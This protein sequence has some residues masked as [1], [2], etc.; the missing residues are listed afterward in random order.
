[1]NF[2][3]LKD[4]RVVVMG[5]GLYKQGSGGMAA[6]FFARRGA[7]VLV[8]DLR[9][10][11]ALAPALKRLKKFE[12][13]EYI[14]GKHRAR[15]FQ[16]ADL[17][18]Q[19]PSVPADSPYLKIAKKAGI[20]IVND[21]SI[22]LS[23]YSPKVFVG[24]TGTRGKSTTTALIFEMLK[25]KH[26]KII[27]AGNL[28]VSPLSFID[29]YHGEPIVAELSSWLLHH[30]FAVKKSPGVAVV[31]NI[32]NDHMDKYR[33][34]GGYI[35][36]KENIFRFQK[37][38][39]T[40]VLNWDNSTTRG[41][42]KKALGRVMRFSLK[43][44]WP[45]WVPLKQ[46]KLLGEHNLAN[47]LAAAGAGEAA[48]V[49]RR[50]IISV[51]KTFKGLP[52]RLELA[53]KA[54]GVRYYND[55]T[56]TTPE[57]TIAALAALAPLKCKMQKSKC[58]IIVLI[59]GG[60]DKKLNYQEL[61]QYI[62]RYCKAVVLLPGTATEKLKLEIGNWKLEIKE[63]VSMHEAIR[64]TKDIATKGDI[65]LLSPAA[66]SFGLF[67]NEFDRGAQFVREVKRLDS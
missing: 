31:T 65:I 35:A 17:V 46:V 57:A 2:D 61:A 34:R 41:M 51:L 10:A 39:D 6:Q 18:F 36:D 21:W 47:A 28:G 52:N 44:H 42:A 53:R 64:L 66:A 26:K 59:A 11:K 24:V 67:K 15:D 62:K 3:N 45:K 22:F 12:N 14:L 50:D 8:T 63:A 1:M 32:F 5:L 4:K 40:V 25:R 30:F 9:S 38:G 19:N 49:S 27:L 48:G 55:T 43:K 23:L 58:K 13:I 20:P 54:R 29:S 60:A 7:R 16:N 37:K 33:D 56:A